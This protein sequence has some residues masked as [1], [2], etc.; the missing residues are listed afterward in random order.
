MLSALG[1]RMAEKKGKNENKLDNGRVDSKDKE[2]PE[3]KK[4][5]LSKEALE[6]VAA[7]F[8]ALG[9]ASRLELLQHLMQGEKSVQE[10]C[11]LTGSSQANISKHLSLLAD[12]GILARRKQGLFVFY[13]IADQ[14]IYTLC[15]TV[16]GAL[17]NRFAIVQKHFSH[18]PSER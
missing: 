6:L 4:E 1:E 14:S 16:C 3:L 12:Q 5:P 10:L 2:R 8:R 13:S 11:Q 15:D 9:E 17:E 7:R 18:S